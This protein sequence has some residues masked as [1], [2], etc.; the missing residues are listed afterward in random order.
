MTSMRT[1]SSEQKAVAPGPEVLWLGPSAPSPQLATFL[2]SRGFSL[3]GREDL[4]SPS[5]LRLLKIESQSPQVARGPNLSGRRIAVMHPDPG[6]ADALAQ[7]LRAK[8]AEVVALSLNP[9]SLQRAEILDPDAV[10]MEASDFSGSCWEIVR[11]LFQHPRLRFSTIVL[12]T[13]ELMGNTQLSALDVQDLT[14]AVNEVAK[15][16]ER[17]ADEARR[18][19]RFSFELESLGPSRSLRA[20]CESGRRL[21]VLVSKGNE[22]VEIDLAEQ[23]IVGAQSPAGAAPGE[24]LLGVHALNFLLAQRAGRVEVRSVDHPAHTNVMAPLDTALH[25]AR[26]AASATRPSGV[27][28]PVA[29]SLATVAESVPAK[30]KQAKR[31][32]QTLIGVPSVQLD[33]S[34]LGARAKASAPS[35]PPAAAKAQPSMAPEPTKPPTVS[36]SPARATNPPPAKPRAPS[37]PPP[38]K[39]VR[40]FPPAARANP[41]VPESLAPSPKAAPPPALP[42]TMPPP[43]PAVQPVIAAVNP[44][45]VPGA[46]GAQA[47][48]VDVAERSVPTSALDTVR[49]DALDADAVRAFRSRRSLRLPKHARVLAAGATAVLVAAWLL[50]RAATAPAGVGAVQLAPAPQLLPRA[51]AAEPAAV[52]AATD[53]VLPPEPAL[54]IAEAAPE[55]SSGRQNRESARRASLLSNQG[56]AFRRKRMLPTARVRYL[57][58]LRVYP[59]YPRALSGLAQLSLADGNGSDAIRYAK[60]LVA[61]RPGQAAY[62]LLL[63]DAYRAAGDEKEAKATYQTAARLGSRTAEERLRK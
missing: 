17:I 55:A 29:E 42:A 48:A 21:R 54:P 31:H 13:P 11:A 44:S 39:V 24:G 12:A 63:G 51:H 53:N 50:T 10:I 40:S 62:H 36:A 1:R 49:L 56:N 57:E 26:D 9:E 4:Q 7:A 23:I 59:D 28:R 38:A 15:D 58:A 8:G 41:P 60:Q 25:M 47:S 22:S 2:R 61:A 14:L 34:L 3:V 30:P 35:H 37:A 45:G 27:H 52:P 19:D 18:L 46:D 16:Y 6:S 20:L 5:P 33:P 32:D 43:P